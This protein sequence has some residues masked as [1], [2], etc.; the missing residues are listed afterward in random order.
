VC[1]PQFL[2]VC[3]GCSALHD[4]EAVA[5]QPQYIA[6]S[7][8]VAASPIRIAVPSQANLCLRRQVEDAEELAAAHECHEGLV[9]RLKYDVAGS[10]AFVLARQVRR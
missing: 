3:D 6:P 8:S 4:G 9:G 7:I 10:E 2:P 1:P 5:L